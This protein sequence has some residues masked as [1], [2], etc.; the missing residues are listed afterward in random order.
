MGEKSLPSNVGLGRGK[1]NSRIAKEC[2]ITFKV[3]KEQGSG[4]HLKT[5]THTLSKT[6]WKFI[7]C[8]L[9]SNSAMP[10]V[11]KGARGRKLWHSKL[12]YIYPQCLIMRGTDYIF[13]TEITKL[14]RWDHGWKTDSALNC[15]EVCRSVPETGIQSGRI[16]ALLPEGV[17]RREGWVLVLCVLQTTSWFAGDDTFAHSSSKL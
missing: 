4:T 11:E 9:K 17:S 2:N 15:V 3:F 8:L 7:S 16:S 10:I 5:H 12:T 1:N 13:Y 14:G 6:T